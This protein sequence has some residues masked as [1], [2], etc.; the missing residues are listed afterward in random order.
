[1]SGG[2][3]KNLLMFNKLCGDDAAKNV[4]LGTTKW[5]DVVETVGQQR[6]QQLSNEHWKHML[7][8]G[9][10]TARFTNTSESAWAI[11]NKILQRDQTE[12]LLIQ[13]EL[14]DLRKLIPQTAAGLALRHNL[15]ELL[16][17][18]KKEA[19]QLRKE[20][21]SGDEGTRVGYEE[22]QRQIRSTQSQIRELEIPLYKQIL[23]FFARQE[24]ST[25]RSAC[26]STAF[27]SLTKSSVKF[28]TRG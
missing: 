14:V 18:Q 17:H 16:E 7:D 28:T 10:K 26:I 22:K 12:V 2:L 19:R 15:Q 6:E 3:S 13:H 9:A 20:V 21:A 23:T 25:G 27:T 1:M 11:V 4:I 24:K 5:A 8:H